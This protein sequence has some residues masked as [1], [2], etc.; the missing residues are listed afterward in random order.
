MALGVL[1]TCPGPAPV[2]NLSS[3]LPSAVVPENGE[4]GTLEPRYATAGPATGRLRRPTRVNLIPP[5]A[6]HDGDE[7]LRQIGRSL[8]P[9]HMEH[10]AVAIAR[11]IT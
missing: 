5:L 8:R 3:K 10:S 2:R 6:Y 4:G 7:P 9:L 1:R 11:Q